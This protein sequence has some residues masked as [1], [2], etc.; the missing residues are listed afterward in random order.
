[1]MCW[2]IGINSIRIVELF[3]QTGRSKLALS[4]ALLLMIVIWNYI[5]WAINCPEGL[6]W[7]F[8]MNPCCRWVLYYII[9]LYFYISYRILICHKCTAICNFSNYLILV[10][11][12]VCLG[13]KFIL[14]MHWRSKVRTICR[15]KIIIICGVKIPIRC[16]RC[17]TITTI[18]VNW[19]CIRVNILLMMMIIIILLGW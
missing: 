9:L 13:W 5:T 8:L 7:W 14:T 19:T 17:G 10:L 16:C 18:S 6:F 11:I 2:R 12:W 1:M 4:R 15:A 3:V